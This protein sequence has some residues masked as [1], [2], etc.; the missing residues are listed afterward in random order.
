MVYEEEAY[1]QTVA[2]LGTLASNLDSCVCC[3]GLM[4]NDEGE[5][6]FTRF[7]NIYAQIGSLRTV[8]NDIEGSLAT[9]ELDD[10]EEGD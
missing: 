10:D 3:I 7:G 5:L 1:N 8:L 4:V 6:V 2:M 9:V